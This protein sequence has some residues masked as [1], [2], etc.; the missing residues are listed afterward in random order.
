MARGLLGVPRPLVSAE[1]AV[2]YRLPKGTPELT[3]EEEHELTDKVGK[4]DMMC[5]DTAYI[6]RE[7]TARVFEEIIEATLPSPPERY[8]PSIVFTLG[9]PSINKVLLEIPEEEIS[10][11]YQQKTGEKVFPTDYVIYVKWG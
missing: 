5:Y 6:D 10:Q 8:G 4:R 2:L 9:V 3:T 1:L 7:E 11:I